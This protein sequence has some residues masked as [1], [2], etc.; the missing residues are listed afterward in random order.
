VFHWSSPEP[1]RLRRILGAE[2]TADLLDPH[3]GVFT[4]LERVFKTG[5]MSL[6][7]SSIKKVAPVFGFSW[8]VDDP[9]GAISQHYLNTLRSGDI[10]ALNAKNWLLRYNADDCT[11]MTVIR[12]GMRTWTAPDV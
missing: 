5:F 7:G 12:D 10:G 11:A 3:T 4:D 8:S 6:H 2:A 1:S 9:G